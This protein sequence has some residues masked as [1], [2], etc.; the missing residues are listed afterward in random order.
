M[1]KKMSDRQMK[2]ALL[3]TQASVERELLLQ[4]AASARDN[5]SRVTSW[6]GKVG[7]SGIIGSVFRIWTLALRHPVITS[8]ASA[9]LLRGKRSRWLRLGGVAVVAWRVFSMLG[10]RR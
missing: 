4:Y 9:W 1:S 10:G 2:I 7:G 6:G 5:V 3:R 8:T